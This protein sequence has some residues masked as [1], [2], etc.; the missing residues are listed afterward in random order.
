MSASWTDGLCL[1]SGVE[2]KDLCIQTLNLDF[3][4]LAG[5]EVEGGDILEL[6]FLLHCVVCCRREET[7]GLRLWCREAQKGG[8]SRE[9]LSLAG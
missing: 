5:L 1:A 3:L 9:E 8:S 7:E 4:L 6:V 2:E